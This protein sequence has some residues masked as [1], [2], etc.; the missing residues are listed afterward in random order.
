MPD[1]RKD[2]I[3]PA[4]KEHYEQLLGPACYEKFITYSFAY[5]RKS[6]RANTLKI[7]VK[8]LKE[9][10]RGRWEL[11]PIP[12]CKEGFWIAYKGDDD[13]DE[14]FDI[15]NL[16]EHALGY[17]YVQDAASMIPPVVLRPRPGDL[18]LDL[19]AAPGSKTSQMAAMMRNKGL[20]VANDL[21]ASRLPALGIN[22]QRVG[23]SNVITT[24]MLGQRF[25]KK[26]IQFDKV[27]VDAPC[28]GTGT[29]RRS[30]KVLQMWS[31]K[32][33]ERLSHTQ[34]KLI[35]A[36][37]DALKPGGVLVYSTCTQEPE[38]NEGVISWLL[39]QEPSAELLDIGLDIKRS[40]AVSSFNRTEY[41]EDVRKCLRIYP[42]D[43]NTEG[44]FVAK[45]KKTT[46]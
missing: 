20:I 31:P 46:L 27:L 29:I 3:K 45:I 16:P 1:A 32:L 4:F 43:N 19:C 15:G 14:R 24:K 7:S 11:T 35:K 40:D 13:Q 12:W 6:I 34:K 36:G 26:G 5:I 18:V 44:F 37:Y 33:V 41:H 38:E 8:H 17:V 21:Q 42:Q 10:L 23:A 30:L 28:S 25:G 39:G 9:R 22:L 2:L